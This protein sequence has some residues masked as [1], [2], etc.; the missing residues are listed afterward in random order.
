MCSIKNLVKI[1]IFNPRVR[2]LMVRVEG[3][4]NNYFFKKRIVILVI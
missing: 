4:S 3:Q 2:D 1:E